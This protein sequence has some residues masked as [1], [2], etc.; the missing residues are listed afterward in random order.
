MSALETERRAKRA[1]RAR[2]KYFMVG[3]VEL[4]DESLQLLREFIAVSTLPKKFQRSAG[5]LGIIMI[6]TRCPV[7][8]H[9]LAATF[10]ISIFRSK[11]W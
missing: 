1:T 7:E 5:N 9:L 11:P 6:I 10:P 2:M 4:N 8:M 3:L